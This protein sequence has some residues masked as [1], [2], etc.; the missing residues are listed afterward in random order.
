MRLKLLQKK[1]TQKT[2]EATG[3]LTGNKITNRYTKISKTLQQ[4]KKSSYK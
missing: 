4:Q 3:D 2:V 1:A